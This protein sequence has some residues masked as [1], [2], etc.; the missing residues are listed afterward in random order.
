MNRVK[1]LRLRAGLQQKEVAMAIGVAR[2]TVSEYEHQKKNPSGERLTKLSEL[3]NVS[4][5]V[6][7]G[8][9]EIPNPVPV[10]F[11]DSGEEN[12]SK[13]ISE[14]RELVSRD[15]ERGILFKLA[16]NGNIRDVRRA[17]AIMDALEKIKW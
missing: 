10:L 12:P 16:T 8:F 14:A 11:V 1:E 13:E 15:P 17:V 9:E 2:A 7:L 3:F 5:S 4:T 6:I